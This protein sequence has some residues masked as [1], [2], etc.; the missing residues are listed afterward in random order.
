MN[1][2]STEINGQMLEVFEAKLLSYTVGAC[3]YTNGYVSPLTS[4]F[5]VILDGKVGLR[6]IEITID[7]FGVTINEITRNISKATA[8]LRKKAELFLPDGFYYTCAFKSQSTPIEKAP[9]IF[10]TK[11]IFEGVRHEA[12]KTHSFTCNGKM[13]VEGNHKTYGRIRILPYED[14]ISVTVNG[15]TVQNI[16]G[17]VII[18]GITKTVT[19]NGINKFAD[20][21][22]T[23]F[24]CFECGYNDVS[25]DGNATVE[26]SYYP[27]FL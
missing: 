1:L 19:Q 24:P 3:K 21:N 7:F 5:P 11:Y 17:E 23:R 12:L 18:D 14:N 9:W 15:I 6:P 25:V 22:M 20:T 4:S 26:I 16:T 8:M 13:F 27:I 2:F 10:Q